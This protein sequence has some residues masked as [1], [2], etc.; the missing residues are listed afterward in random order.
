MGFFSAYGVDPAYGM[1]GAHLAEAET[2]RNMIAAATRL[3][4]LADHTKFTRR[5][6]V[7][8]APLSGIDTL[9]T[10]TGTPAGAVTALRNAGV[11][12][13]TA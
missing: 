12:V 9:V 1:L 10:D 13:V 2:D 3:V 5:S 7:R 4:V 11:T 6:A 8:I